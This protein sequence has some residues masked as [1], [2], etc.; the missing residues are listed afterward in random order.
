MARIAHAAHKREEKSRGYRL[1]TYLFSLFLAVVILLLLSY[2]AHNRN[3][4]A[5]AGEQYEYQIELISK[6]A[7]GNNLQSLKE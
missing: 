1:G 5:E 6:K 3:I 2:F 4:S 7:N